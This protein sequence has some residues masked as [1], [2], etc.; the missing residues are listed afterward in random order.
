MTALATR[1][2]GVRRSMALFAVLCCLA[3]ATNAVDAQI[4]TVRVGHFPNI[5]HLQALVAHHL[6]RQGRGWYEERLGLGV[7]IEWF[8][9]NAG[10]SAVEMLARIRQ[11]MRT[12]NHKAETSASLLERLMAAPPSSSSQT[13]Y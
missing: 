9:Y 3:V 10:P 13:R 8:V 5:T 2:E 12:P 1:G 4:S 11:S 7:K 6:T